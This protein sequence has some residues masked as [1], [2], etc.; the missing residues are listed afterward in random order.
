MVKK[1]ETVTESPPLWR[2]RE[3]FHEAVINGTAT[4][5]VTVDADW[6]HASDAVSH[7]MLKQIS[8]SPAKYQYE[9]THPSFRAPS[10]ALELGTAIHCALLEPEKFVTTYAAM[11]KFDGRTTVGKAAK[12]E[13]ETMHVG[14]K[15]LNDE[16][17][18]VVTRVRERVI[19]D[20]F[21]KRFFNVGHKEK[22][23]FVTD[24]ET[25]LRLRCRPDN[26]IVENGLVVDLKTTEDAQPHSFNIDIT[27]YKY[28]TQAAFYV[29]LLEQ[30]TGE[31]PKAFVI[32]AVEKERDCDLNAYYFDDDALKL[33]RTMYRGWLRQLAD[34][35]SK[36]RW[37]GYPREFI[38]YRA[39][40]WLVEQ[41]P[42][43]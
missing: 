9:K 29:D 5:F 40:Q 38:R 12:T 10:R 1:R 30:S 13:W 33:G 8:E 32:V 2:N 22:S 27:K 26:Y 39:P 37:P 36:D 20:A 41:Y 19:T 35:L 16:D 3:E 34:C 14:K 21:Y 23:F 24:K 15:G 25:G 31:R 7:S 42:T 4:S 11:P 28:L 18:Q 6:Y 43:K 17:W